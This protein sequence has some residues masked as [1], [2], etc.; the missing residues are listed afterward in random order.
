MGF[1]RPRKVSLRQAARAFSP[2]T[3]RVVLITVGKKFSKAITIS[4]FGTAFTPPWITNMWLIRPLI[5]TVARFP[6]SRGGYIGNF[7]NF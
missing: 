1:P 6:F 7:E 5:V 3:E 4:R 2:V